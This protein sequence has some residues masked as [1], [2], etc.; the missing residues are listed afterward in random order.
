LN[1]SIQTIFCHDCHELFD[2]FI[3]IRKRENAEPV[4]PKSPSRLLRAQS[5][6]P[7]AMLIENPWPEFEPARPRKPARKTFWE[8]VKP[9]CPVSTIHRVEIWHDPGRCPR[10]GNY[11]E[12]NVYPYR[13]WE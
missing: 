1:C 11:L 13:L 2:I 6:I 4:S 5:S 7:P 8:D 10:C 12:K 3:R 9:K